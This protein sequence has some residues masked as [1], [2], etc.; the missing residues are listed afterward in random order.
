MSMIRSDKRRPVPASLE[1][2]GGKTALVVNDHG[3][4][5]KTVLRVLRRGGYRILEASGALHAKRLADSH[6][7]IRL[8]LADSSAPKTSGLALARWF[9]ARFPQTMILL[10]T[11][12]LWELLLQTGERER[13]GILVKPF[14][15][16]ELKRMVRG[17]AA[18]V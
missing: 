4:I 6:R 2:N 11:A 7:N 10:T 16:D 1:A 12:S 3:P 13:F 8:V 9:K 17:L 18:S 5:H 15:A 14:G